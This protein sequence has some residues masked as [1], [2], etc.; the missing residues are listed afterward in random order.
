MR[1][2]IDWFKTLMEMNDSNLN[3]KF[4]YLFS[5]L[6][7]G[8]SMSSNRCAY[9]VLKNYYSTTTIDQLVEKVGLNA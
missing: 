4:F 9:Y 2:R 3:Q 6:R 7:K 5:K 1:K 8:K